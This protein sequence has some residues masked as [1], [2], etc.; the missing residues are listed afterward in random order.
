MSLTAG[1]RCHISQ[2]AGQITTRLGIATLQVGARQ[3]SES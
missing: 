3:S 1:V 2:M